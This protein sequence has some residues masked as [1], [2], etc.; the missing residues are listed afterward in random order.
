M[1]HLTIGYAKIKDNVKLKLGVTV[2]NRLTI[3]ENA[4][5]GMGSVVVK[6]VKKDVYF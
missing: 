1:K 4:L 5:V 6:D 3:S 2:R